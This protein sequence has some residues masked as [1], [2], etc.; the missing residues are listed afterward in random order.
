M[1]RETDRYFQHVNQSQKTAVL[2]FGQGCRISDPEDG[3]VYVFLTE[4]LRR[5]HIDV[6]S[7]SPADI[8]APASSDRC[9]H[10]GWGC[11]TRK[12]AGF[13]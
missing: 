9:Y 2:E 3:C 5:K 6:I 10:P 1:V 13:I 12:A 8:K 4:Q 7:A 11:L